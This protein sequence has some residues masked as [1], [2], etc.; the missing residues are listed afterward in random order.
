MSAGAP[1]LGLP[2]TSLNKP[3]TVSDVTDQQ[4][5]LGFVRIGASEIAAPNIFGESG[6]KRVSGSTT[7]QCGRALGR[8]RRR[9]AAPAPRALL[10]TRPG[11][12]VHTRAHCYS[13]L[14]CAYPIGFLRTN[15]NGEAE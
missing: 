1:C 5:H 6:V 15:E 10:R 12:P 2:M 3:W 9:P 13:S 11:P 7:R 8:A 4:W 14:R